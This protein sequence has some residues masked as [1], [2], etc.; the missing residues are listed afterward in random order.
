MLTVLAPLLFW[1]ASLTIGLLSSSESKHVPWGVWIILTHGWVWLWGAVIAAG[2]ATTFWHALLPRLLDRARLPRFSKALDPL[3][4]EAAPAQVRRQEPPY[5][6]N[7]LMR[8]LTENDGPLGPHDKPLFDLGLKPER[9]IQALRPL[10]EFSPARTLALI[11]VR[12]GGKST[13]LRLA[14]GS[15]AAKEGITLKF[16]YISLWEYE[17][18]SAAIRA[19]A[20]EILAVT[21]DQID[22]TPFSSAAGALMRTVTGNERYWNI[23]A[24][25]GLQPRTDELLGGLSTALLLARCR[26]IICIEDDDRI[27]DEAK[28]QFRQSVTGC[29]DYLR[30][31]PGFGYVICVTSKDWT[32]AFNAAL[33]AIE[34]PDRR[35]A[36]TDEVDRDLALARID[37]VE[38]AKATTRIRGQQLQDVDVLR[39][40]RER[41]VADI[42]DSLDTARLCREELMIEPLNTDQWRPAL[43]SVRNM[44]F[45]HAGA[46]AN[47]DC[48]GLSAGERRLVWEEF[49]NEAA[50]ERCSSS[51]PFA[52]FGLAASAEAGFTFTPRI[53][54][55]GLGDAWRKWR[56]IQASPGLFL[57]MIDPDSVLVACLVRACRPD[58]WNALI[59]D[60]GLP[61]GGDWPAT[62]YVV[63]KAH[64]RRGEGAFS[65]P[66]T[67]ARSVFYEYSL[68]HLGLSQRVINV[69]R[70]RSR[71]LYT[72]QEQAESGAGGGE[73]APQNNAE[74]YTEEREIIR[75]GGLIGSLGNSDLGYNWRLFL[76]A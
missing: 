58:V 15:S 56:A 43:E 75:P 59:R 7:R 10:H 60:P 52:E 73:G 42:L 29:L 46:S 36:R 14:E 28:K 53:L 30:R 62:D 2:V 74:R 8:W 65:A 26:V 24:A 76:N 35:A 38:G 20:D 40:A 18:A 12:G 9:V 31:F 17:S 72:A 69:V 67:D 33:D 55:L 5:K 23:A 51:Q 34:P 63:Q 19:V 66:S 16:A 32:A 13:L 70:K 39:R 3:P 6:R 47:E 64:R 41:A 44:M 57:R 49:V 54:R 45:E 11:G 61:S 21:A 22:T 1:A 25:F 71:A 27:G 50:G 4:V 37:G 68:P 48:F